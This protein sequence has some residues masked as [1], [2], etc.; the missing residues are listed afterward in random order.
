MNI[1]TILLGFLIASMYGALFHL[2]RGGDGKRLLL[3]LVVSWIGFA[4]GHF[5]GS[6]FEWILFPIGPLD[7]GAATIG[8]LL[9]LALGLIHLRRAGSDGDAV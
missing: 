9:F 8:S 2:V 5:A 6:R 3:Y 7:F 4:A 1:S